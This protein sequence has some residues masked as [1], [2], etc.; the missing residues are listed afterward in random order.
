MLA[1]TEQGIHATIKVCNSDLTWLITIVY[2]SP[3]LVERKLLWSNLSQVALLHNLPWLLLGDFNEI[4]CGNDK[5]KGRQINLNR[6]LEF[7]TCLDNYNFL[8]LRFSRPKYTWSNL[9]QVTDLI[10]ERIDRCF[11]NPSWRAL[12]PEASVTHLPRVFFDHYPVLLELSRLPP[13][14]SKKS[15]SFHTIWIHHPEFLDVVRRAWES[16]SNLHSTIKNFVDRAKVWNRTA[17]G[18]IFA[19]K[20]MALARLNG[21]QKALSNGP[22]HFLIQLEKSLIKEYSLIMQQEEE[23]WALKSRLNW[24]AYGDA[25]TSY[26]HVSTLVKRHRNKIR[27]LKNSVGEWN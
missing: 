26:F 13:T 21:A 8:D 14:S 24:A 12:F 18:N 1:A 23:Y 15:F 9:K 27:S 16:E 11:A 7:K 6:A 10:L 4:L 5:L 20:K 25:N 22:N 19:Q 2:A 3:R 17:F